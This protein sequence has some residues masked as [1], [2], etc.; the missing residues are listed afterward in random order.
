MHPSRLCAVLI[1]LVTAVSTTPSPA[2]PDS[3]TAG[4]TV[5]LTKQRLFLSTLRLYGYHYANNLAD[6][7][8]LPLLHDSPDSTVRH[9]ARRGRRA[10][11]ISTGM[12]ASGYGL[13]LGGLLS[14]LR[15][16]EANGSLVLG[17]LGLF[18]GSTLPQRQRTLRF[19]QAVRA[20]NQFVRSQADAYYA[21]VFNRS[22][23][24]DRLSLADTVAVQRRGLKNRYTYRGI[25]VWP[26]RQLTRLSDRLADQDV[27]D[28]FLYSRR[29]SGIAGLA[30]SVGAGLLSTSVLVW[31]IQ[32]ANGS[33]ATLNT[34]LFWGSLATV[35][36][37]YGLRA[38][39]GNVQYRTIRLMN[40]RLHDRF[41]KP[42]G[43]E[44]FSKP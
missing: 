38:H 24:A 33:S 4:D 34:P 35:T 3:R 25:R 20:H 27:K 39:V 7:Q 23:S 17:G 10:Q 9:Y 36:F 8:L 31:G 40:E 12:M 37:S 26:T 18:F 16:P 6:V 11:L 13:T 5:H 41:N 1:W 44:Y 43:E 28:G 14:P 19:E 2:Q 22:P 29:V 32:R 21:P 42:V 30:Y 15:H